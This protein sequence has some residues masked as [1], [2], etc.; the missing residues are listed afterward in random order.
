IRVSSSLLVSEQR[1]SALHRLP[2]G[3]ALLSSPLLLLHPS[4]PPLHL[5]PPTKTHIRTHI[6]TRTHALTNIHTHT[7]TQKHTHSHAHAHT[8]VCQTRTTGLC[9]IPH[10]STKHNKT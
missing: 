7:H 5:P 1:L 9:V 8:Q 6:H 2:C 10:L 3:P 4:F